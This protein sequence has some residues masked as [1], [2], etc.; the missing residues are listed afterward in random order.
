MFVDSLYFSGSREVEIRR[1]TLPA[2]GPGQILVSTL[3]SAISAGTE[4]LVY[5]GQLPGGMAVD[6]TIAALQD[7]SGYP[8]KFGYSAVGRVLETGPEA[9]PALKGRPVFV[10][11]PHQT[12]FVAKAA[13]AFPIPQDLSIDD[14]VFLPNLE[15]ALSLVMDAAPLAGERV[16]VIGQGIVGVLAT[17]VLSGFPLE[18]LAAVE[19]RALRRDLA[20]AAGAVEAFSPSEIPPH[21]RRQF[22]LVLELSGNPSALDTAIDLAGE[23][24]RI[25]VGSW[26]GSKRAQVA[27][28]GHFHRGR[29]QILSSQVSTLAPPL[30]GRWTKERRLGFALELARRLEP[31]HF[32][33]RRFPFEQAAEAYRLIDEGAGQHLQVV[34]D[35][36]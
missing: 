4:M 35:Y 25:V 14:A 26:Y 19:P 12:L 1:E 6:K 24:G 18:G 36:V 11:Q 10:F 17:S 15:T 34:L 8:M 16:A 27:L 29:L 13:D 21:R 20:L 3:V 5:R 2:P 30:R 7:G 9:D 23:E 22:D 28:G 32:I 33:T 31:S